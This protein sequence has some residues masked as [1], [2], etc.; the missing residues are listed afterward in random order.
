M[1]TFLEYH[2]RSPFIH[3]PCGG[4]GKKDRSLPVV[5]RQT[6]QIRAVDGCFRG[7]GRGGLAAASRSL[8]FMRRVTSRDERLIREDEFELVGYIIIII[9]MISKHLVSIRF[10]LFATSPVA[11]YVIDDDW[12]CIIT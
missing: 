12:K 7:E 8:S 6:K 10:R 9:I 4:G 2:H 11:G 1:C 5:S 3:H